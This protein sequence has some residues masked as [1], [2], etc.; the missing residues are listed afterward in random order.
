MIGPSLDTGDPQELAFTLARQLADLRNDRIARLL[1][2][3]PPELD[4]LC[5]LATSLA[6]GEGNSGSHAARW[7]ST[8]LHPVELDQARVIGTRLRDRAI[9]PMTAALGWLAATER[10]ADRIGFVVIGDLAVAARVLE[11]EP[12]HSASDVNRVLELLWAST[13]EEVLG[14]RAR[15]EGWPQVPVAEPAPAKV[16]R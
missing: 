4:D 11:R 13:T 10:A 8:A 6:G 9:N 5:E 7:L 12:Q 14:V 2:P 1:C 3:R 16:A 15:L